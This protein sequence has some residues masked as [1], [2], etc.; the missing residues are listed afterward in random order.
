MKKIFLLFGLVTLIGTT[1]LSSASTSLEEISVTV[2]CDKCKDH[3]C[4]KSCEKDGCTAEKCKK[5]SKEGTS[6]DSKKAC[7]KSCSHKEA[8]ANANAK[9]K[10][11]CKKG[12][13]SSCSKKKDTTS[14]EK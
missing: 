8:D 10:S 14:S 1:N 7:S 2:D 9:K 4:D 5:A 3:K 11:C 6:S 13:D 12:A